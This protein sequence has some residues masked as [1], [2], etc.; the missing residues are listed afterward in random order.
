LERVGVVAYRLALPEASRI[1]PII[2]VSQLKKA[3]GANVQVQTTL[4]SPLDMFAVPARVLQR[5]LRQQGPVAVSQVLIQWSGQPE[6]LATW[7]DC[8]DLKRRF[9][10]APAWGQSGL[11]ERGNVSTD[12][13]GPLE[14][15]RREQRN[16]KESTRYPRAVYHRS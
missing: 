12:T 3:V 7:E 2:H 10:R 11:Q 5:R 13:G 6:V 8:D 4:P 9:P 15:V 16:R 1:H 14:E